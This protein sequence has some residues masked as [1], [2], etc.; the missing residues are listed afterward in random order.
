MSGAYYNEI[1]PFAADWLRQLIARGL[2]APGDVDTRSITDVRPD[3]LR[4]YVQ[5]H[6]FAGIG[7]WSHALRLAGWSDERP[8]WTGSCPCQPFSAAGQRAGFDDPRHL[9]PEWRRLIAERRPSRILGEQSANATAWLRLVRGELEALGYAVGAIPIEAASAGAHQLG[10]RFWLV[11]SADFPE[12]R[13]E[14]PARQQPKYEHDPQARLGDAGRNYEW[15]SGSDG[16]KRRVDA[17]I[18]L[19]AHGIPNRVG[20]LRG[21]GNAITPPVAAAFIGAAAEAMS[22]ALPRHGGQS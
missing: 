17:G 15:R 21:F 22:I 13:D 20:K 19:F 9:W 7:G 2:I 10:D 1:D 6:F 3:D 11:A 12:L 18:D 16:K 5:C 8:V 4:G 14:P